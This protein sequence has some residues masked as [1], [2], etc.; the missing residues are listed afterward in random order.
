MPPGAD[1]GDAEEGFA[2]DARLAA[3]TVP[4]GRFP[5]SLLL[6]MD[7]A[8]YPWCVLVPRRAGVTEIFQLAPDDRAQLLAESCH[9]AE[10]LVERFAAHKLNVAALGNVVPQ[11]H[12][13]HV[14]RFRHDP[15]WPHPVW[16]RAPRVP[17]DGQGIAAFRER[18]RPALAAGFR[19]D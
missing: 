6:L 3:D 10:A 12:L 4:L 1:P 5:L 13:H 7:D 2:L 11:L 14:A 18:L 19:A 17:Y 15:A 8:T 16:G 9:L